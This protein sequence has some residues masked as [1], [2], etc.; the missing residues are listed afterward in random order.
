MI[1]LNLL[2]TSVIGMIVLSFINPLFMVPLLKAQTCTTATTQTDLLGP[3]YLSG[4]DKTTSIGPTSEVNDPKTH[5]EVVGRILSTRSCS[6]ISNRTLYYPLSNVTIE[7]WYAGPPDANGSYYQTNK[8]RGQLT[9]NDCGAF[10]YVQSFPTLYPQRPIIH[11]HIRLSVPGQEFLVTQ[12]Y[13]IGAGSGYYNDKTIASV[14]GRRRDLQA[15][16][17]KTKKS[18][19][20]QVRFVVFLSRDGNK[21]CNQMKLKSQYNL[22]A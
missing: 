6:K 1:C 20:R 21:K 19:I 13:Y 5:L 8:Y 14:L 9:T 15:M 3:F 16:V 2:D 7:V 12:M 18:G 17:V 10:R 11:T 4:S 22:T